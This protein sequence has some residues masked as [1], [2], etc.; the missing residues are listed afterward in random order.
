MV[1]AANAKAKAV[2]NMK[3]I[4]GCASTTAVVVHALSTVVH[5]QGARGV[6]AGNT[7]GATSAELLIVNVERMPRMD[8]AMYMFK[9]L[10]LR[11]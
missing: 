10:H 2:I 8:F 1:E 11:V 9:I 7:E 3:L 6:C 5:V 4:K